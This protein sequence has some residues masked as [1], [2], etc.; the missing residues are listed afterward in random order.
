MLHHLLCLYLPVI[1]PVH[2]TF[3]SPVFFVHPC[4]QLSGR[5]ASRPPSIHHFLA[6]TLTLLD[7]TQP[8]TA[9]LLPSFTLLTF[10]SEIP[11]PRAT[12]SYGKQ[13][14]IFRTLFITGPGRWTPSTRREET[15]RP[16][17]LPPS[18]PPTYGSVLSTAALFSLLSSLPRGG[19][20]SGMFWVVMVVILVMLRV[21]D[22]E[23]QRK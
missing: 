9:F 6:I 17:P 1:L 19:G 15:P 7:S 3:R 10:T 20:E 14:T 21:E 5:S 2:I 4:T 23:A 16:Q 22:D 11:H 8:N 12:W 13:G 18:S